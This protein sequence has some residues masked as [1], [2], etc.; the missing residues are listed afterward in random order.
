MNDF[1]MF[2]SISNQYYYLDVPV[3]LKD[4]EYPCKLI[5]KDDRKKGKK[6]DS[7]NVKFVASVRTLNMGVVDAYIKVS[8]SNINIDIKSEEAWVKVIDIGKRKLE[9]TLSNMGFIINVKVDKKEKEADLVKCRDF[10]ED[11]E[12]TRINLRV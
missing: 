11:N 10:F 8:N 1:K 2:N 9:K 3:S 6:I 7:T 4:K 5:I 12:F